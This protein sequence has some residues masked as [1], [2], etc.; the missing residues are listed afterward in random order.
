M[1]VFIISFQRFPRGDAGANYL[2]YFALALIVAGCEVVVIGKKES[3][4]KSMKLEEKEYKGIR[5]I[6]MPGKKSRFQNMTYDNNFFER[7]DRK[8]GFNTE[9][10]YIFYCANY[11]LFKYFVNKKKFDRTYFIRVE[12]LQPEQFKL[13]R[14]NPK[15]CAE[16]MSIR[17]AQKHMRGTIP[18]SQRLADQDRKYNQNVFRL[19]IMANTAEYS[20]NKPLT[21]IQN[22]SFVYPGLKVTG[23]EDDFI[24]MFHALNVLSEEEKKKITVHITGVNKEKISKMIDEEILNR[25]EDVLVFHGFIEYSELVKIYINSDFL[26]LPRKINNITKANFPSK[27]PETMAFGIIP[28]C[29]NVG[30]YTE[31]YLNEKNSIIMSGT[32]ITSCVNGLRKAIT[33]LPHERI[34][35][36]NNAIKLVEDV[37]DYRNWVDN[38]YSFLQESIEND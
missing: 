22:I 15:Y 1:R 16:R 3:D 20:Y 9:D 7:L 25:L 13:G 35:M 5:Y 38:I 17:Y 37:F 21:S 26:I 11:P 8:Y 2:Q 18:I 4:P 19:P 33:M 31:L 28:I 27:I 34:A 6:N 30:D 36:R 32:G 12:D 14:F 23:L 29:T 10:F 24:S